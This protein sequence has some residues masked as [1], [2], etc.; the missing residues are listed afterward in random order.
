METKA[1]IAIAVVAALV[2]GG[3]TG[4]VIAI[5]GGLGGNNG[6]R[7]DVVTYYGNG[8]VDEQS[9]DTKMYSSSTDVVHCSFEYDGKMF[10]VWN[11]KADGTGDYYNVGDP[12]KMG[13]VLYAIWTGYKLILNDYNYLICGLVLSI[14]DETRDMQAIG[15]GGDVPLN[16]KGT[17]QLSLTGWH[18]NNVSVG[19]NTISGSVKSAF[20]A[21]YVTLTITTTGCNTGYPQLSVND[22]HSK[23]MIDLSY[24]GNVTISMDMST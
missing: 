2:V 3:V 16:E 9:G 7:T 21:A 6:E 4:A 8:G 11:T 19:E 10:L 22:D 18:Y 1:I 23:A 17:A 24:G 20:G 5:T 15:A 13:V 14:T 12:V